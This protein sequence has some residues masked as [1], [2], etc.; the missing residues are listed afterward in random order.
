MARALIE[1][2][3]LDEMLRHLLLPVGVALGCN[4]HNRAKLPGTR[5]GGVH[6]S[7][8]HLIHHFGVIERRL[9][10]HLNFSLVTRLPGQQRK[11]RGLACAVAANE[12]V[13]AAF[14]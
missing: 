14:R 6:A 9:P 5:V 4:L 13:D 7:E 1:A 11:Q 12:P 2:E 10:E 8:D 3:D